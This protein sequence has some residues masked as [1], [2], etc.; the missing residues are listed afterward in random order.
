[1]KNIYKLIHMSFFIYIAFFLA[2]SCT[3]DK[4]TPH[5]AEVCFKFVQTAVFLPTFSLLRFI[6]NWS[7]TFINAYKLYFVLI[8][9][10]YIAH[11]NVELVSVLSSV[12]NLSFSR[13]SS[14]EC[15]LSKTVSNE[16]CFKTKLVGFWNQSLVFQKTFMLLLCISPMRFVK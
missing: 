8:H 13:K 7:Q 3:P 5:F 15:R 6:T 12:F 2:L 9:N 1:M 14:I 16:N 11:K 10:V 4:V